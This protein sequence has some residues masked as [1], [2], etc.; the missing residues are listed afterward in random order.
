[1]LQSIEW[2]MSGQL[3]NNSQLLF[4]FNR[5]LPKPRGVKLHPSYFAHN[6]VR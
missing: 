2:D 5:L 6:K 4:P 3:N 1:M